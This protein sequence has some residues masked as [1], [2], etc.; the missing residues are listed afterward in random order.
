MRLR[1]EPA[2]A[3][4]PCMTGCGRCLSRG[5]RGETLRSH[6]LP[7]PVAPPTEALLHSSLGEI[8]THGLMVPSY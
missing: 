4:V 3:A 8:L 1:T 5:D 2:A 6:L 7:R